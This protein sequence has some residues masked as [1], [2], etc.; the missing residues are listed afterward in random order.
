MTPNIRLSVAKA[1]KGFADRWCL[2]FP[3]NLSRRSIMSS[4]AK[5]VPLEGSHR[6]DA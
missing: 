2:M 6:I 3:K 1:Q 5:S 4:Q